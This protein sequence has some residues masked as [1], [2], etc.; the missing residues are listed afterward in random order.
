MLTA[1]IDIGSVATKTVLWEGEQSALVA[2]SER[3]T[4]WDPAQGGRQALADALEQVGS[5]AEI[6]HTVVTGY[7]R[8]LWEGP[9]EAVTEI[10]CLARGIGDMITGSRTVF[11]IGGQDSKVLRLDE[12]GHV[13][14]F[15]LNDRCAAGTGRFLEVAAHR[16]DLTVARLGKLALE[17]EC[18]AQ[19]SHTCAVFAESEIVGLLAAGAERAHIAR[20]LCEAV[21]S[22]VVNLAGGDSFLGPISFVGGVARNPGVQAALERELELAVQVPEHPHLAVALGAARLAHERALT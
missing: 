10:T 21:A 7:G 3:P 16:L 6:A 19:L 1:G 20:G 15:R 12:E 5:A 22:Q 4:S 13:T 9:G 2:W 17:A 11:D 18:A 8:N 14:D